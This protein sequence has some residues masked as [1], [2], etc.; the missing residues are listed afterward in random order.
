M[1]R[2]SEKAP[3]SL[4]AALAC[5][6]LLAGCGSGG[7][8]DSYTAA[9]DGPPVPIA[10]TVSANLEVETELE[11]EGVSS[12]KGPDLADVVSEIIFDPAG[13]GQTAYGA[14]ILQAGQ[15]YPDD[16]P[17]PPGPSKCI[18]C[19]TEFKI[20]DDD[21]ITWRNDPTLS[22]V[23]GT[24]SGTVPEGAI[25]I[26]SI[27]VQF[28]F[29]ADL[30]TSIPQAG[31]AMIRGDGSAMADYLASDL[32]DIHSETSDDY[33]LSG[34]DGNPDP[35]E[36]TMTLTEPIQGAFDSH[37]V[38]PDGTIEWTKAFS[39]TDFGQV[40]QDNYNTCAFDTILDGNLPI[41]ED[42]DDS[43]VQY[44][45]KF[46]TDMQS[47][48]AFGAGGILDTQPMEFF[49][50]LNSQLD[51]NMEAMLM[52]NFW[53]SFATGMSMESLYTNTIV[54]DS[55]EWGYGLPELTF[56]V[57]SVGRQD[58][59]DGIL[60][61]DFFLTFDEE[62]VYKFQLHDFVMMFWDII[63]L[64]N[65]RLDRPMFLEFNSGCAISDEYAKVST[66]CYRPDVNMTN[67]PFTPTLS[68]WDSISDPPGQ[69]GEAVLTYNTTT[70]SVL[71]YVDMNKTLGQEQSVRIEKLVLPNSK[72]RVEARLLSLAGMDDADANGYADF[73]RVGLVDSNYSGYLIGVEGIFDGKAYIP[74]CFAVRYLNGAVQEGAYVN[75]DK[76]SDILLQLSHQSSYSDIVAR[77]SFDA[78]QSWTDIE[79]SGALYPGASTTNMTYVNQIQDHSA[80]LEGMSRANATANDNY[81]N[82]E[83][84]RWYGI[85]NSNNALVDQ[86][87]DTDFTE[88][89]PS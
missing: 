66:I 20:L 33:D 53:L 5:L 79:A 4:A 32:A 30:A 24:C 15:T 48:T 18:Q 70:A 6:L 39:L 83:R 21:G 12:V 41:L 44:G 87:P 69:G 46:C 57:A 10:V 82:I 55:S 16:C 63:S 36:M 11:I 59:S 64:N 45:V 3:V 34:C 61:D 62:N 80:I 13:T 58:S 26:D 37:S 85:F 71:K 22:H 17:S 65:E 51:G 9:S 78:G 81:V 35:P 14:S 38:L 89:P 60:N 77:V 49:D 76:R 56:T 47:C 8:V 23:V 84:I 50:G 72:W 27:P 43:L 75:C 31:T 19:I 7:L 1:T 42:S 86:Y 40:G 52:P 29:H 74:S 67:E 25:G 54:F 73:I 68:D 2:E 88:V 28:V